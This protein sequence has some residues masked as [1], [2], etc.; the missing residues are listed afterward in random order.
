METSG[1]AAAIAVTDGSSKPAERVLLGKGQRH[2]QTLVSST[3]QLLS[4]LA[5][6]PTEIDVVAVS[7]GPGSFT[8]LRVGVVFAKTFAW[9]NDTRLVAVNTLQGIAQRLASH[10]VT[11]ISDAQREEVFV[12]DYRI[13]SE[14]GVQELQG[15]IRIESIDSLSPSGLL[16]GPALTRFSDRVSSDFPRAEPALW[17]PSAVAVAEVAMQRASAQNWDDPFALE[18]L[19]IRRSYAEEKKAGSG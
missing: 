17:S 10:P 19:Y 1:N 6:R 2:A 3:Q 16:T 11:V 5:I 18:P 7:V 4:D 8:G 15:D 13:D 9:L 14:T 12:G